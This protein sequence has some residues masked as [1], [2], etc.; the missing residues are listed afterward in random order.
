[1]ALR[2]T[3]R[4]AL[5][6]TILDLCGRLTLAE[7]AASSSDHSKALGHV[8]GDLI[9]QRHKK[10]LLN[11]SGLE[12]LDSSGIGQLVS[13]LTSARKQGADV[14]LL[15]PVGPVRQVLKMT[16]LD[17]IFD[18]RFDEALALDSFMKREAAGE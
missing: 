18:I 1:M 4:Q 11:L 13:A 8:I 5:D 6:V 16:K 2:C 12:Q 15:N 9:H 10:I 3:M 17:S 14:R 7:L